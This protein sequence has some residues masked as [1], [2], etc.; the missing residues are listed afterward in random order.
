MSEF[1][2]P[3]DKDLIAAFRAGDEAAFLEIYDRYGDRV[4][5]YAL[6]VTDSSDIAADVTSGTFMSAVEEGGEIEEPDHF[7][8]WLFSLARATLRATGRE[9]VAADNDGNGLRR[10]VLDAVDDLGARDRHLMALHL[11]E[12]LEG[13]DLALAMGIDETNLD[14]VVSRMRRRVEGAL[15]ALLIA[16]LGN[17]MCDQVEEVLGD[18]EEI[19]DPGLRARLNRHIGTCEQ[20]QD[21]RAVLLSPLAALPGILLVTAPPELRARAR[22]N[23]A[24]TDRSQAGGG[25]GAET[26]A[27][28]PPVTRAE[29][30][31]VP[32]TAAPATAAQLTA[33]QAPVP[34]MGAVV[35]PDDGSRD[36]AKLGIF[37]VVTIVV[38]LIGFSVAGRFAPLEVPAREAAA[39][40]VSSTTTTSLPGETTVA[41]SNGQSTPTTSVAPASPPQIGVSAESVDLGE[42]A[43]SAEFEVTNSGGSTGEITFATSSEAISLSAGEASLTPGET[44]AIQ[45]SLDRAEIEEGEIAETITV[46]WQGGSAEVAVV[47]SNEDSPIIHNPQANPSEVQA[48][49]G[50]ACPATQTTISARVRDTSAIESV[51]ARWSDGSNSRETSMTEV[52]QDVFEGTVGPFNAPQTAEVRVVAFDER[53]NAGGATVSVSVLPCP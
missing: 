33:S 39:P 26:E 47:G 15:G 52:G 5:S 25:E 46:A 11:V 32:V 19:Y 40:L 9:A 41:T 53:G 30:I 24:T 18:W 34:P 4:Y 42:D 31:P 29:P 51:V 1:E 37:V 28:L 27:T 23:A 35:S 43:T 17:P 38:G 3:P 8:P 7:R 45:L 6:N 13:E 2:T 50:G 21:R 16:R 44:T 22:V 36:L 48:V 10:E 14:A 12:G 49:G 20:C